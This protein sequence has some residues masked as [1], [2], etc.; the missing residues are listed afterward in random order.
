MPRVVAAQHDADVVG[1]IGLT[2]REVQKLGAGR[3]L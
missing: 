2:I 1:A 3:R